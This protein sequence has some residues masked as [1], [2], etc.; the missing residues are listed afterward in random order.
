MPP[1]HILQE[2]LYSKK[3]VPVVHKKITIADALGYHLFIRLSIFLTLS[4]LKLTA[5]N[6]ITSAASKERGGLAVLSLVALVPARLAHGGASRLRRRL[7]GIALVP[8]RLAL[9]GASRLCRRLSRVALVPSRLALS[10]ASRLCRGLARGAFVPSGFTLSGAPGLVAGGGRGGN[11]VP[12]SRARDG[13]RISV[14]GS[15]RK[16]GKGQRNS[17]V[18]GRERGLQDGHVRA[19][20]GICPPFMLPT[21][22]INR[23][24]RWPAAPA[25][26]R[27]WKS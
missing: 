6:V 3:N 21:A 22:H 10:G 15:T 25:S 16:N 4:R 19:G 23:A 9:S 18:D 2:L 5:C 11:A 24:C 17:H 8:S 20:D 7:A 12:C 27:K 26:A 13:G 1:H 14:G